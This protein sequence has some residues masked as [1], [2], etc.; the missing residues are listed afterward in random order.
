MTCLLLVPNYWPTFLESSSDFSEVSTR[1]PPTL[2]QHRCKFPYA[3]MIANSSASSGA[4]TIPNS[5]NIFASCS[6]PKTLQQVLILLSKLAAMTTQPTIRNYNSS[7][8]TFSTWMAFS[9]PPTPSSKP[10]KPFM[11]PEPSYRV[12]GSI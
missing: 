2:N 9:F 11:I 3:R 1:F 10:F 5:L 4:K 12:V 7:F 8:V 6:E